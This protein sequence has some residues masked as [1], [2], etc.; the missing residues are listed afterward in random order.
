MFHHGSAQRSA[1]RG[2]CQAKQS[3]L[4]LQRDKK[5]KSWRHNCDELTQTAFVWHP[6]PS[7]VY[8]QEITQ[9]LAAAILMGNSR[10]N[11]DVDRDNHQG[12]MWLLRRGA[13]AWHKMDQKI[14]W[15]K[16]W[17]EAN[18]L[19][20][21]SVTATTKPP[22]QT[23]K[24]KRADLNMDCSNNKNSIFCWFVRLVLCKVKFHNIW[25]SLE[26]LQGQS[27]LFE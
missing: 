20:A 12:S 24:D 7:N 3:C 25:D 26:V 9:V 19:F 11:T 13:K 21:V 1:C 5:K 14:H 10:A 27:F 8:F 18:L 15:L 6:T 2:R 22:S 17:G 23:N 4:S 16:V